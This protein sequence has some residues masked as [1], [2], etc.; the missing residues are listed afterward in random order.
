M[1]KYVSSVDFNTKIWYIQS[2][3]WY[4]HI[5][6]KKIWWWKIKGYC[7]GCLCS[8]FVS[9]YQCIINYLIYKL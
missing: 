7:Q 9:S 6:Y 8:D 4:N 5:D 3:A 1:Y 2:L